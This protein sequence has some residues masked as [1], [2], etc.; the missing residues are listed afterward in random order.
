VL[1][2]TIEPTKETW[3]FKETVRRILPY[4]KPYRRRLL[5]G[6]L[7][8]AL[9]DFFAVLAPLVLKFGIQDL[10]TGVTVR[11]IAVY[12]GLIVLIALIAGFFRYLMRRIIVSI[13]RHIEYDLRVDYYRHL[14]H[15]PPSFYDRQQT[16]DLMTRAT[17]DIEAVRMIV[18]PAVMYTVDTLLTLTFAFTLMTLLSPPLTLTVLTIVPFISTLIYLIAKRIHRY[19]TK[20][21]QRYSDLNA[22]TQEH[23]SGIRVIRAYCRESSESR[24]YEELN[25]RYMKANMKLVKLQASLFPTFYS[26][27]GIG[28]AL[29]LYVGGRAIIAGTMS[30]GDFVA[31]SAYV[32]MLA[33]PVIAVGWVL[34]L[35][36]RGS[37]SCRRIAQIMDREEGIADRRADAEISELNGEIR[38]DHVH[39]AYPG[40]GDEVLCDINLTIPPGT[41]LG[42]VGPVG[43]GKS[44]LISLI[45]RLYEVTS[46]SLTLDGHPIDRI[47]LTVLRRDIAV[48]P[49][50]SFLFSD[51]LWKNILFSDPEYDKKKLLKIADIAGL[52]DDVSRFPDGFD[53]WV[54]E[55]GITLSGGQ[56]QRVSLARALAA[57][58]RIL[59][60]D[61]CFSSVDT[62]TEARIIE[63]LR[64]ALKSKTVIITAHRISTLQWADRIIVL[65]NG[66][67]ME[68]GTHNELVRRKGRYA[69]LYRKQLLEEELK[70]NS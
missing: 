63:N 62:N 8:I 30:L 12:A 20:V 7:C 68:E 41:S 40:A 28:M 51:K 55:R 49:Q 64:S 31:F 26:I 29:I 69:K 54:G 38:F 35:F 25:L 58:P 57:D 53:T 39:F 5:V 46:G 9:T 17:S 22:M 3:S 16:G 11:K 23:L 48:L 6:F 44:S 4:F 10:E 33:W 65:E 67:I 66:E 59:I 70:D 2:A 37:A 47:S 19:S 14:Q 43:S 61:D 24:L 42:I 45:P 18:G 34:N 27:F 21:Q 1:P 56:K 36:Q 52:T 50:D 60:L 32:G 15:L 13:S